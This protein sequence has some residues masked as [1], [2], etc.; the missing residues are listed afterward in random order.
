[1]PSADTFSSI[2]LRTLGAASRALRSAAPADLDD[3]LQDTF[4]V[5]FA[6]MGTRNPAVPLASWVAGVSRFVLLNYND[7]RRVRCELPADVG[8][9]RDHSPSPEDQADA[10]ARLHRHLRRLRPEDRAVAELAAVGFTDSE[11][12][13]VLRIPLGTARTRLRRARRRG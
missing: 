10:R 2:Y 9:A 6:K 4:L 12:A 11:I 1:M 7:L 3:L 5:V 13:E 8:H